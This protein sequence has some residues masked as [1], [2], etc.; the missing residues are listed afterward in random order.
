[1]AIRRMD[2]DVSAGAGK[3]I[4]EDNKFGIN[5]YCIPF[6]GKY[7]VDNIDY[8]VKIKRSV[9]LRLGLDGPGILKQWRLN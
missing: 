4:H 1:M 8:K 6:L 7:M 3:A 5:R 2:D 9:S